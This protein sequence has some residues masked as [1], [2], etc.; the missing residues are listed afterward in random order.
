MIVGR[1]G[2]VIGRD[3]VHHFVIPCVLGGNWIFEH[4]DLPVVVS[5]YQNVKLLRAVHGMYVR[6][7]G[8]GRPDALH[9]PAVDAA[10]LVPLLVLILLSALWQ[11]LPDLQ[12]IINQFRI[13]VVDLQNL[14]VLRKVQMRNLRL[15][16]L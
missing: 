13:L 8:T 5:A 9:R 11:S 14:P 6:A 12:V 10:P 4:F 2:L 16:A 15:R 3:A 1:G 7:G